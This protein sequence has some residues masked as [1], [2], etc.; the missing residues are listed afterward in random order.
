MKVRLTREGTGWYFAWRVS[1]TL[2]VVRPHSTPR[3]PRGWGK[4]LEGNPVDTVWTIHSVGRGY[5]DADRE[6]WEQLLER[7][8]LLGA[9]YRTLREARAA[10]TQLPDSALELGN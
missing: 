6:P 3:V 10:L 2:I 9:S 5:T 8:G 1:G 7:H 4:A